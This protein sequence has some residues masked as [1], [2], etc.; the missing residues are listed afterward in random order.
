[1]TKKDAGW[2]FHNSYLKLPKIF[3]SKIEPNIVSL[4]RL[5]ILNDSLVKELGL[6]EEAL[7]SQEGIGILAGNQSPPGGAF[8]AQAYAGHQF[9]HFTMLGDGRAVLLGEQIMP[10]GE[11]VDIQLKGSGRTP[12]SR[13]GD[14]RA[15][16]G[17]MLR[18]YIIS[19]SMYGLGIPTTRSL[20]VVTTGDPIQREH[21]LPG[22]ILT[23]VASSHIRV[24]TFQYAAN[25]GTLEDVRALADFSIERH[26]PHV[27]DASNPYLSLLKEV[28]K[29]QAFL[30]AKWQLVGFIHGV[31]NTDNMVISGE[32]IDYGPCAFMNTY[33]PATVFSSI[34]R[35]G[36][37]AYENQ[38]NMAAWNITRFAET[39]LPLIHNDEQESI[40][41]AETAIKEYADLYHNQWLKGM[42]AKLGILDEEDEDIT[43]IK[44]LLYIMKEHQADFTNTFV[45]LTERYY[46]KL[47]QSGLFQ[48]DQFK[49]WD[50]KWHERLERGKN[51]EGLS[52]ETMK[53]HNPR[54]IPRNHQ[55][56]KALELAVKEEDYTLFQNLLKALL[57]PYDYNYDEINE[58]YMLPPEPLK[59]PY[60]TFCGT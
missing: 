55:V 27:K 52:I 42:R 41:I 28:I 31:M 53:K 37:Y 30:I 47:E 39:L 35:N 5:A 25:F 48:S 10:L 12:Y 54:I 18:E 34:D 14:G 58:D 51:P 33:D 60:Q 17:P 40:N 49:E 19:E 21:I 57:I 46:R 4:P 16:L 2:N 32:T 23:R 50:Q 45:G 22:A 20:A 11:K 59:R 56:E 6:S 24:G 1:M 36:R 8:I 15:A 44:Q 7:K 43:L 38:P 9:G 26:F 29:A 13:G 3:Y